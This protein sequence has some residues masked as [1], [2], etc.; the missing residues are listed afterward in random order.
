MTL[1]KRSSQAHV[2]TLLSASSSSTSSKLILLETFLRNSVLDQLSPET[3]SKME[4]HVQEVYWE[5]VSWPTPVR[6]WAKQDETEGE[7]GFSVI[8]GEVSF[9]PIGRSGPWLSEIVLKWHRS[10]L[11]VCSLLDQALDVG[12]PQKEAAP[13]LRAIPREWRNW[14]PSTPTAVQGGTG[15]SVQTRGS[16]DQAHKEYACTVCLI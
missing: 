5:T 8:I 15:A 2:P 13:W 16:H 14:E 7:V 9:A 3:D 12:T 1:S 6:E 10:A 4:S 11:T